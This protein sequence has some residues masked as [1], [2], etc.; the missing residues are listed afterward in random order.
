MDPILV[1]SL[2]VGFYMAWNIGANDV[3]NSFGTSVGSKAIT[4]K[5]AI[6]IAAIF[7]F[8]GAVL[9]GSQV[10]RTISKGIVDISLFTPE[11]GINIENFIY[12]ML[13]SVVAA[14]LWLQ[15]ATQLGW[16]VSTSHS[17]VGA[18]VGFGLAIGG[19]MFVKWNNLANIALSW[20]I[21][22]IFGAV[23]AFFIFKM[24]EH[25][26]LEKKDPEAQARKIVPYLVGMTIFILV[27]SI[28]FEALKNLKLGVPPLMAIPL[29]LGLALISVVII[30][31]MLRKRVL[32]GSDPL[33]RVENIFKSLQIMTACY[34]AFAHGANDVANAI[35]PLAGVMAAREFGTIAAESPVPF[36]LLILGGVG[37]VVG[38]ATLG[39]KVISTIGSK[40]TEVTPTRGF[41]AEFATATTVLIASEMGMPIS[42][43]HTIVGAVIGV[44]LGRGLGALNLR[45]V[46]EIFSSWIVTIP[47][48]GALSFGLYVLCDYFIF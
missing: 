41:S 45:A 3:A 38:V 12:G 2:V 21:S 29:A 36:W 44:A 43:T 47:F 15:I 6:L 11:N 32:L 39:Y 31:Q 1:I 35:G 42:T 34:V 16:P 5:Q 46:G 24:I 33:D 7:E 19:G 18:V 20:L 37:I 22:P 28:I 9:V 23:V 26:I 14:G 10:T 25:F 4:L 27:L 8:A 30:H 40:L 17:I 48:T 13:I